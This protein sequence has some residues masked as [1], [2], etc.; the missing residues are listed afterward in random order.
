MP[1]ADTGKL[2]R[3]KAVARSAPASSGVYVMRDGD[4]KIIY[5]GKAKTLRDRL[6]SYFTGQKDVKTRILVSRIEQIEY[7]VTRDEY[8][9]LLLENTLIKQHSPRYNINLKDGKT[10]PSIRITGEEFPRIFR[11]RRVVQD[12]STY[13]GPFPGAQAID[14]YLKLVERLFPLRR[15]RKMRKRDSPCM[16]YHIGR[17]SA[18]CAGKISR[19]DYAAIVEKAKKLLGGDVEGLVAELEGRMAEAA[20]AM[21]FEAAAE[22]RDS[23]KAITSF[24]PENEVYD[25]DPADRDYIAWASDG[26]LVS[27]VAIQM[28]AGR[29]SGRDVFRSRSLSDEAETLH[30]FL[31]SYYGPDRRPP[32]SVYIMPGTDSR[33]LDAALPETWFERELGV[34]ASFPPADEKRHTA[35]LAL[36]A[37]NA[38]EDIARRLREGGDPEAVDALKAELSLARSPLRIEGFDIAHLS[39][40]YPVASLVSFQNGVPDKKNY[41]H[42]R[43]KSLDGK[44]DDFESMREAVSRRYSRLLNEGGELPDLVMVDGGIGQANAARGVLELLDFDVAVV[45]LAKRDEEL[46]LPGASA[47]I[48]LP[49]HSP[50]LRLLQRVRDET[51]R[52]ATGLNQRLRAKALRLERLESVAGVGPARARN[53]IKAFGSVQALRSAAVE[54]VAEKAGIPYD[55][56]ARVKEALDAPDTGKAD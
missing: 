18:P 35:A 12:G 30:D 2:G 49:R 26:P 31:L 5:I 23:I 24:K 53:I 9:A 55:V 15:C 6:S 50:A 17:C 43:L 20:G 21:R 3:L 22:L 38:S 16:Y 8:E 33:P 41:R 54:A 51:H 13:F 37:Q 14:A 7:I 25:F 47:P 40:L 42:F 44:I 34:K 39:G 52:F 56:A 46:W 32:P 36:A 48:V 29:M 19:E 11:T 27:F 1:E 45:G 10:Y 4:G 28:R